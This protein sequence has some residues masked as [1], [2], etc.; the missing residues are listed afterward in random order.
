MV[1]A[2]DLVPGRWMRVALFTSARAARAMATRLR[3]H[4]EG[5]PYEWLAPGDDRLFV[6]VR[7]EDG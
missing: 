4:T 6:R 5:G 2:G 1:E 7:A 3:K